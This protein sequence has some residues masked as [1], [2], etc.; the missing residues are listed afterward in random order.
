M[1]G[2]L[3]GQV[4]GRSRHPVPEAPLLV[5][6]NGGCGEI[7]FTAGTRPARRR[8]RDLDDALYHAGNGG[9]S[10]AVKDYHVK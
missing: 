3:F 1:T 9:L 4:L 8:N 7:R 10:K 2:S 5:A 6:V